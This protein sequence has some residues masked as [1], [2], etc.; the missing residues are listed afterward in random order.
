[1]PKVSYKNLIAPLFEAISSRSSQNLNADYFTLMIIDSTR[2]E[3][4]L[5]AN[6]KVGIDSDLINK[7]K[8]VAPEIWLANSRRSSK[9]RCTG[10]G[11]R[12]KK[13]AVCEVFA[14]DLG[15]SQVLKI[16]FD[17]EDIGG[18]LLV[19]GWLESPSDFSE[20]YVDKANLITEQVRLSL[21]LSLKERKGQELDAKL[22]AL[23][24]LSTA[25]Y[26]SLNYT[27][28][29]EKA[30]DLSRQII[31]ADGGSIFILDKK[32][33]LLKP[34]ITVDSTHA[35]EISKVILKPG[36]G[37]TGKVAQT[38]VGLISNNS[39][40]DPRA[41]QVPGTPEEPESIISAPLTWS[42]E[43]IGAITL[44]SD[45]GHDFTQEDLDILTIFA[46]QTADAIENAK[47]YENLEQAYKKLSNTQDQLIMTEKLR[48]LGEM[49]GGVA[50]DFNNV[51]GTVL[52]R[53]Q[54]L[55]KELENTKWIEYLEQI[56]RVTLTGAQTVQKLQ[57]FTRISNHG[58]YENV[59]LNSVVKDAIEATKPRWKDDCQRQGINIDL[60]YDNQELNPIL[61]N[62]EELLEAFSNLILNSVDALTKGGKIK[63]GTNMESDNAVI[64][65]ND[66]GIGMGDATL[67]KV[68]HPF[69]TTKGSQGTGLGLAVVYGIISRHKGEIDIT[70]KEGQG[71]TCCLRFP[72]AGLAMPEIETPVEIAEEVMARILVIDDDENILDV[73][74]DM[75]E[76]LDHEVE[77]A[78]SGEEGVEKFKA[79]KFDLVITDLGMPGISGWDVT[80]I[81]KSLNPEV[82]VLMISGW[83]NQIDDDMVKRSGLDGIMAKPFE[84]RKIKTMI[85][86]MISKKPGFPA[87]TS[88]GSK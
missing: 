5:F 14:K 21:K 40:N 82:P 45:D 39:E 49:A 47:L 58:Q 8:G 4:E 12:C 29:L 3:C 23:L 72:T 1:M 73:I 87:A 27:D 88:T 22:A 57:N 11:D 17:L 15:C 34:L 65:V 60:E 62:K 86:K 37:L 10:Y 31:G 66:N 19:W 16:P 26:S 32:D 75:L 44:R 74:S 68:F 7:L 81:C 38:G 67:N 43:V 36:E 20:L 6:K 59:D 84:I 56:E 79:G 83:G 69:F 24:E 64:R 77:T 46:R 71:T 30:V 18:G 9:Y 50:H 35:D 85:Q 54:L 55:M 78:S 42:G 52:G 53:T 28:V 2:G 33:N 13:K 48:A 76:L 41:L 61:G 80:K 63:I 51:L 25:I 70:S